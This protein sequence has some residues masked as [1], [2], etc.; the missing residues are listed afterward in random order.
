MFV[1]GLFGCIL[2]P[3][4]DSDPVFEDTQTVQDTGP[5]DPDF[6]SWEG[7]RSGT[8]GDCTLALRE[9]GESIGDGL[10]Q[11]YKDDCPDCFAAY[12][13][14]V[15]VDEGCDLPVEDTVYRALSVTDDRYTVWSIDSQDGSLVVL[16]DNLQ[17]IRRRLE[18]SYTT[19]GTTLNGWVQFPPAE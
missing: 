7:G 18:Y 5:W 4:Q 15:T 8:F 11:Q 3:A 13:V 19:I 12:I 9:S 2:L 10:L 17:L 16:E 1:L 6:D 14:D